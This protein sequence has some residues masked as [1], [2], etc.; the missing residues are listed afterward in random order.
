[1]SS[2]HPSSR[3]ASSEQLVSMIWHSWPIVD[4]RRWSWLVVLGI[5]GLGIMVGFLGGSALLAFAAACGLAAT[6]W[7]F[8][9]PVEYEIAAHGLRRRVLNRTRL[10]PW[11]AI[12]AF[13]IRPTGVVLYQRND[14]RRLDLLRSIFVPNPATPEDLLEA[15]RRYASHATRIQRSQ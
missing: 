5:V 10:I 3:S 7:Q 1:M 2:T 14:P 8:F 9:L 11:H 6:L 12:R 4:H 13:E 15:L